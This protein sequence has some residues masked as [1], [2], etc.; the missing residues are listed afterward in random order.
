VHGVVPV[1]QQ[2]LAHFLVPHPPVH[3]PVCLFK[4][5]FDNC[6]GPCATSN[7]TNHSLYY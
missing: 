3:P 4:Q 7:H 5:Y 6:S 1:A 2:T